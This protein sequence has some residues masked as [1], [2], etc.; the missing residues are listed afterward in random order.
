MPKTIAGKV[1]R[2]FRT[3]GFERGFILKVLRQTSRANVGFYL[4]QI[5]GLKYFGQAKSFKK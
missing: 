4:L 1:L 2:D 3:L 5:E